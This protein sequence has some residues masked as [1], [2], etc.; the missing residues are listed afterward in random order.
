MFDGIYLDGLLDPG[1]IERQADATLEQLRSRIIA[2][3]AQRDLLGSHAPLDPGGAQRWRRH[4]IHFWVERAVTN[5]ISDAGGMAEKSGTSWRLQ[6][7]DGAMT[8][9][10]CFDV[11][12]AEAAPGATWLTLDNPAVRAVIDD[13][14]AVPPGM[15]ALRLTF[16]SLPEGIRGSWSL[17]R[18]KIATARGEE[19][20]YMPLFVQEGRVF[21]PTARRIWEMMIGEAVTAKGTAVIDQTEIERLAD[22]QAEAI[23]LELRDRHLRGL[24]LERQRL[25]AAFEARRRAIGR[26]GLENVRRARMSRLEVDHRSKMGELDAAVSVMPSL[27][28]VAIVEVAAA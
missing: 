14:P 19:R 27:E 9:R 21:A 4:P 26:I 8:E 7:P 18:I 3:K 5:G 23:Y 12:G 11:D 2:E 1:G 22:A 25:T 24:E 13:V 6:W 16:S 10:A 20:R 15:P 17:W 28:P